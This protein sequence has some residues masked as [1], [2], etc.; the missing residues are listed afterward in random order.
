M[1]KNHIYIKHIL[2]CLLENIILRS[3]KLDTPSTRTAQRAPEEK[4]NI[5][6]DVQMK[7]PESLCEVAKDKLAESYTGLEKWKDTTIAQIRN[8]KI[9]LF[10]DTQL[11][12]QNIATTT[13]QEIVD[14]LEKSLVGVF[15]DVEN[16]KTTAKELFKMI[17]N[18]PK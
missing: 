6:D 12:R 13:V 5:M 8:L 4:T 7:E 9:E 1:Y 18:K 3:E 14:S 15:A 10:E 17:K 16:L 2:S 11:W